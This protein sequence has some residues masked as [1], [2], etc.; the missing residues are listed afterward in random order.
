MLK[1][2]ILGQCIAKANHY[3][4]VPNNEN[5]RRIIKD[6]E[7]RAY[8]RIFSEQCKIYKGRGINRCFGLEID[9][10]ANS[11]RYDLDNCLKTVLDC[12]QQVGA[13]SNDNLC[14]SINARKHVD[15]LNP[16]VTFGIV[17]YE[18]T[19]PLS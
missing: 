17:E 11:A 3:L 1:E 7:I 8:E 14:I 15:E 12:L 19:L 6:A 4:A 10:Y 5:G 18:P 16:R 9:L 13:I 2:T